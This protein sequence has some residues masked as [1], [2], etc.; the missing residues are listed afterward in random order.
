M[1]PIHGNFFYQGHVFVHHPSDHGAGGRHLSWRYRT[2]FEDPSTHTWDWGNGTRGWTDALEGKTAGPGRGGVRGRSSR[3]GWGWADVLEGKG[4]GPGRAGVRGRP[5]TSG[6]DVGSG[7][8]VGSGR[9]LSSVPPFG[10]RHG[11]RV[12]SLLRRVKLISV[13]GP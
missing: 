5:S 4:A 1:V 3:S 7:D 2:E 13:A 6:W 12:K 10:R 11:R 8:V 9:H